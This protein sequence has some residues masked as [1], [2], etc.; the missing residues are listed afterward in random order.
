[1]PR[2]AKLLYRASEEN[3]KTIKFHEKCEKISHTLTLCETVHGKV[4]GGYT[5]LAWDKANDGQYQKDVSGSSFIFS[6]SNNH[7]FLLG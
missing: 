1:M 3:F 7:K 4:I 2:A 6:L 5:P